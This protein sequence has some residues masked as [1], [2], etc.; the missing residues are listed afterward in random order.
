MSDDRDD[1]P[2]ITLV[3]DALVAFA[4]AAAILAGMFFM[5]VLRGKS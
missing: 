3:L 2:P 5:V 1:R 4:L